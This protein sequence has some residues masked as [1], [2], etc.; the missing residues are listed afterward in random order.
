MAKFLAQK[1]AATIPQ[2]DYDI[3]GF[4]PSVGK[5]QRK[6]GYNQAEMLAEELAKLYNLPK[7]KLLLRT[8]HT[9]QIGL[10]RSERLLSVQNNFISRS[11]CYGKT[12]LLVDDVITTGATLSECS[13]TLKQAGAKRVWGIAIA[14]K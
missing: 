5:S 11:N 8:N 3:I 4:V 13:N 10:N 12:I 9:D 7:K 6:R 2:L 14:K 1:M